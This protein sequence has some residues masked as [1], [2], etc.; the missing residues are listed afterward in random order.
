MSH[1]CVPSRPRAIRGGFTLVE[2]LVVIAIIGVLVALLLPAVQM[3]REAANR[4]SCTNNLKQM[5]LALHN[6]HD[7]F[8]YLPSSFTRHNAGTS[9]FGTPGWGWQVAI[10]PQMEQRPLYDALKPGTNKAINSAATNPIQ[11]TE[12]GPYRCPSDP[13]DAT[14]PDRGDQG[15]SSYTAV[16]GSRDTNIIDPN[17]FTTGSN[18]KTNTGMFGPNSGLRLADCLDGTSSTLFVGERHRV[19]VN[20][21]SYRGS[22]WVGAFSGTGQSNVSNQQSVDKTATK[23]LFGTNPHAFASS[24]PTIVQFAFGDASVRVLPQ[25]IDG[26]TLMALADRNEGTPVSGY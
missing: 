10:L 13:A 20:G 23:K 5:G 25:T 4:S 24:H 6:Y 1:P 14:N 2:L 7:T 3:A 11:Q 17:G 8:K 22:V 9:T 16:Y 12:I 26:D 18:P 21:I 15:S 19:K